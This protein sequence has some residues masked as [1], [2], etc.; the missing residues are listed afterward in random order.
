MNKDF[1][2]YMI[3]SKKDGTIYKGMTSNLIKRIHQ[4]RCKVGGKFASAH[5]VKRLVWYKHCENWENAVTLEKRLRRYSRQWKINLIEENNPN[6]NDL[7]GEINGVYHTDKPCD[8]VV[9]V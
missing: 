5:N 2:V 9:R 1:Y 4:H 6:W 8:D 3:A 7:W